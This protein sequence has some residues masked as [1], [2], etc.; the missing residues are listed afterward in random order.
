M[1][2]NIKQGID[3]IKAYE[4]LEDGNP[5]TVNLDP[6]LCPAGVWTIGWGHALVD[7]GGDQIRGKENE[8]KA[9]TIFPGGITRKEALALLNK[10]VGW[11]A[12]KIDNLLKVPV[13]DNQYNALLSFVYNVGINAFRSSTLLRKLNAGDYDA[14]P[15]Q[16]RR[17]N[18]INGQPSRGLTRRREAECQ[19][20][21]MGRLEQNKGEKQ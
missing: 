5:K 14:V 20:W 15:D 4:G 7:V 16:L 1:K 9:K 2:R 19:L 6:Y 11:L 3:L 18:K 10:D 12:H 21:S 13:A 8:G 17:W